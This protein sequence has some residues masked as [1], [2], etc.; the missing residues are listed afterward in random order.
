MQS[1]ATFAANDAVSRKNLRKNLILSQLG[2][3]LQKSFMFIIT[4][5]LLKLIFI[6]TSQITMIQYSQI[7]DIFPR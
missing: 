5:I 2:K 1:K 4:N 3:K 7:I 6:P